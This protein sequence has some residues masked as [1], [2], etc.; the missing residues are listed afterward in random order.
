VCVRLSIDYVGVK[1]SP[2]LPVTFCIVLDKKLETS[3]FS[4]AIRKFLSE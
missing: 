2:T 3:P 4:K 1:I